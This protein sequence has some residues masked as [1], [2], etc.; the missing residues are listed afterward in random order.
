MLQYIVNGQP[1]A[2]RP[3]H[4]E[5]FESQHEGFKLVGETST[6]VEPEDQTSIYNIS[7]IALVL[8]RVFWFI[9]TFITHINI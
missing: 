8:G 9:S 5:M 7:G 6:V 1:Y 4:K 3:E 2:V